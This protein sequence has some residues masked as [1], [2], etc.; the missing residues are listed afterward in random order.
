MK[1]VEKI[2]FRA[3]NG[4]GFKVIRSFCPEF[5]EMSLLWLHP[6]FV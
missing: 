1:M 3:N 5:S 6:R 2:D 4:F